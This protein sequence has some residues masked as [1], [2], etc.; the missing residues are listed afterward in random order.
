MQNSCIIQKKVVPLRDISEIG[1]ISGKL[2]VQMI[3][4]NNNKY[5]TL[6]FYSRDCH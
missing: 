6:F 2:V 5:G 4:K 3:I 1:S